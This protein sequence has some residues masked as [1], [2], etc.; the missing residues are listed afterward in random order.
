MLFVSGFVLMPVIKCVRSN[1]QGIRIH[2]P[3]EEEREFE[4]ECALLVSALEA[5]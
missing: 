4:S 1:A 3:I 2:P 5:K